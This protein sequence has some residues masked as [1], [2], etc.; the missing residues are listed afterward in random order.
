[1]QVKVCDFF[2]ILHFIVNILYISVFVLHCRVF[3]LHI[4][5]DVF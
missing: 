1:M 5:E 3:V 4:L 2:V